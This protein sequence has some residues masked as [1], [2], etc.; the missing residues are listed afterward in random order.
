MTQR[1]V[2]EATH[3]TIV[4]APGEEVYRLLA[5]VARWPL[6]FPPTVHAEQ[7]EQDGLEERIRIWATANDT[8]KT[9]TSR[10][11]LDPDGM[12]IDFRQEVSQAPV[13]SMGGAWVIEPHSDR[14]CRVLLLHDYS[15]V[16]GDPQS[17]AWID[18]AVDRNS[19]AELAAL[20]A[21]AEAG[22][23]DELRISF[24]DT[25]H[26]SGSAKDV[27]DF[28]NEAQHWAERL[29]HVA[30]VNLREDVE[31]L[32]I[33]EMDT[34][35]KDGS[36]HSTSSVRVCQPY[37]RIVYKQTLLP[38]LM[39]LHTGHWLLEETD[40]GVRVTSR[41]TVAINPDNVPRILGPD[42]GVDDAKRYVRN[43]LSTNSL[44]TL[45]HAAEYAR[46]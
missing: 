31:G 11:R 2:R 32:Q 26:I 12:R 41:H 23:A 33:L 5:D 4:L 17:L 37:Q 38:A 46:R 3:E 14:E 40:S 1:A 45:Q 42:A 19:T 25:V 18:R 30:R 15:A 21:V 10:R 8:A 6:I 22:E 9:W 44:A 16:D 43:A 24:D 29:P 27:Y 36:V 20:K 35:T 7:L 34:M 28:L 13:A 39:T